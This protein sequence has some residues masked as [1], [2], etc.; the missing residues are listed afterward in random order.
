M[1][2][3]LCSVML[4]PFGSV[5]PFFFII[6]LSL[7]PWLDF[8]LLFTLFYICFLFF[9]FPSSSIS[10]PFP[11]FGLLVNLCG[12]VVL[13]TVSHLCFVTS[14]DVAHHRPQHALNKPSNP[15]APQGTSLSAT[16][17]PLPYTDANLHPPTAS[18]AFCCPYTSHLCVGNL[19]S[20]TTKL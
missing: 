3:L 8:S 19:S 2:P 18:Q 10:G 7:S 4:N 12:L 15:K 5:F 16:L 17:A 1:D 20:L 14:A 6:S 9:P 13:C 11:S